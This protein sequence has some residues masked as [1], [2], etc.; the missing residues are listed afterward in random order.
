[1]NYR[2][3]SSP[4]YVKKAQKTHVVKSGSN[5]SEPYVFR[6]FLTFLSKTENPDQYIFIGYFATFGCCFGIF[7][8]NSI[9]Y[10]RD[11]VD[12]DFMTLAGGF[13]DSRV[14]GVFVG[15]KVGGLDVTAVGILA[16]LEDF[17]VQFNVVVVDGI[18]EGNGDHH[19]NI[20]G[21]QITG[22]GG[23]IF[24]AETIGQDT[25]SG[26]TGRSAI[27]IVFNVWKNTRNN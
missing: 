2:N 16:A 1:M 23:T 20:L 3:D 8:L 5:H 21:W 17:L 15:N 10:L 11:G 26:V 7:P 9:F 6:F 13:L 14:V 4:I 24:R 12:S 27:G 22:N 25:D 19:G 18:I